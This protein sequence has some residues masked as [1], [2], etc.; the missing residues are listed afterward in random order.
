MVC[1]VQNVSIQEVSAKTK[2]ATVSFSKRLSI[3]TGADKS[4][5]N[6]TSCKYKKVGT[7]KN[8]TKV[9]VYKENVNGWA[10]IKY[11]DKKRYI[12]NSSLRY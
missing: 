4:C 2:T 6:N 12:N 10:Q 3:Y 11:K 1:T 5:L 7:L 8:K 9:T